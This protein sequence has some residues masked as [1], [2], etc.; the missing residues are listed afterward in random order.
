MIAI[1]NLVSSILGENY[2]NGA[3]HLHVQGQTGTVRITDS[4]V[5]DSRKQCGD[6]N[7][8]QSVSNLCA[9]I[10]Y[11][12]VHYSLYR[13]YIHLQRFNNQQT[14]S[15]HNNM[16]HYDSAPSILKCAIPMIVGQVLCSSIQLH[17]FPYFHLLMMLSKHYSLPSELTCYQESKFISGDKTCYV[18]VA[19]KHKIKVKKR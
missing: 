5:P 13:F 7:H 6:F 16:S 9:C 11:S 4:R 3:Q 2:S 10:C 18:S 19:E 8:Y 12:A 14:D 15:S 1:P 17:Y